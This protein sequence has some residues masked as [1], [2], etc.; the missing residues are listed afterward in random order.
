MKT[1]IEKFSKKSKIVELVKMTD[2][3]FT[4]T[5][6]VE[7]SDVYGKLSID[8]DRQNAYKCFD[9]VKEAM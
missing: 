3:T 6:R 5:W 9:L 1:V 8:F 2:E 7:V 4:E